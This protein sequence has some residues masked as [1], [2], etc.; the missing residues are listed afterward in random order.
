MGAFHVAMAD[1]GRIFFNAIGTT[2]LNL[3]EVR[4]LKRDVEDYVPLPLEWGVNHGEA[5]MA[6]RK[7]K[8]PLCFHIFAWRINTESI[9]PASLETLHTHPQGFSSSYELSIT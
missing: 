8:Q 6:S 2:V 4:Y 9:A 1:R 3:D 5:A 7:A